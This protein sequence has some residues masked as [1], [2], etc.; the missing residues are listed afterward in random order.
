VRGRLT[1]EP[2]GVP[3]LKIG[4]PVTVSIDQLNDWLYIDGRNRF[5]GFTSAV[6][7]GRGKP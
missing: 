6:L 4:D 3:K 5:G 2:R 1:N 7:S